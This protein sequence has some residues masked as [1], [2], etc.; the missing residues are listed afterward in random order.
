L[1]SGSHDGT[2]KL[3]DAATGALQ[4]TL[5]VDAV[6]G[7]L[8][9]SKSG[10]VEIFKLKRDNISSLYKSIPRDRLSKTFREA[11]K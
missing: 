5:E 11:Q 8:S 3:W 1:A 7:T 9:F 2:V 6:I 4:Q 10:P